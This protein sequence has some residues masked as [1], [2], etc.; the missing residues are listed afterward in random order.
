MGK[1]L[2]DPFWL[3][4]SGAISAKSGASSDLQ[5]I[6]AVPGLIPSVTKFFPPSAHVQRH[7][8]GYGAFLS[9]FSISHIYFILL[10]KH[11]TFFPTSPLSLGS[12]ASCTKVTN[13]LFYSVQPLINGTRLQYKIVWPVIL[14]IRS[15][16][17]ISTP[18]PTSPRSHGLVVRAV[19]C[20]ARGPGFDSS[21]VQMFFFSP[22]VW[23]GRN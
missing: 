8:L 17:S 10:R 15:Y 14:E 13:G 6:A 11:R 3:A 4:K 7:F 19:A 18:L 9:S 16:S 23:G 20:E 21:S 2:K 1:C 22:R 5:L 12:I